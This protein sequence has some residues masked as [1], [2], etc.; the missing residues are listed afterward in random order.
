MYLFG[1][2]VVVPLPVFSFFAPVFGI[3]W[4]APVVLCLVGMAKNNMA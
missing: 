2:C 3:C 1:M 4:P